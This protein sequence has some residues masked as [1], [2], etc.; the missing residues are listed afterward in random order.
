MNK[1]KSDNQ[2]TKKKGPKGIIK[3]IL[4][5]ED[6]EDNNYQIQKPQVKK[7]FGNPSKIEETLRSDYTRDSIP[8]KPPAGD[9]KQNTPNTYNMENKLIEDIIIPTG[10]S[11]KPSDSQ[12]KEFGKR[13]KSLDKEAIFKN[14]WERLENYENMIDGSNVK[15][16]IVIFQLIARNCY[17]LLNISVKLKLMSYTRLLAKDPIFLKTSG[18]S[19]EI[20]IRKFL[21]LPMR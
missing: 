18:I 4:G 10:I 5:W 2:E 3:L 13:A 7:P 15:V 21:I 16:F 17:I 20:I 12:L 19:L 1:W 8:Y 11:T 6:D 9:I 14:L